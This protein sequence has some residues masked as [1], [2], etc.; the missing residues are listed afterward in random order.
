MPAASRCARALTG[1]RPADR[2][3]FYY[4]PSIIEDVSPG[5]QAHDE[6]LFGPVAVVMRA[7]NEATA[8]ALANATSFGL[9]GSVWTRDAERGERFARRLACGSA[10][11][12]GVVKS[13]P[14]LPCGG[15]KTSGLGREL[16]RHGLHEFVNVK[17]IWQA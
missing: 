13:D 12:N 3:G 2:R 6:E 11:V 9:G 14:R 10:F 1:C 7:S 4:G 16:A 8:L 5:T 15:I 17:T